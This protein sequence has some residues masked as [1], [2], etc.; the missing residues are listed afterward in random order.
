MVAR[1]VNPDLI[2]PAKLTKKPLYKIPSSTLFLGKNLVSLPECP[3]TNTLALE[4]AQKGKAPDGTV[5]VTR[6]QT[7]G[8]GQRG[9]SWVVGRDLNLTFSVVLSPEFLAVER[10]FDLNKCVSL[11]V[12]DVVSRVAPSTRVKWPNDILIGK[13]KVCGILIENTLSRSRISRS[14]VG[15]GLNVNQTEF[16][17]P[18]ATSLALLTGQSFSLP[19][20]FEQVLQALE[21]RY[22]A[23][24]NGNIDPL[25][26]DYLNALFQMNETHRYSSGD[27]S[28]EGTIRGVTD[29]GKLAMEVAGQLKTFDFKEIKYLL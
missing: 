24:R 8:R 6:H 27:Q 17:V 16:E 5:V 19:E 23:L 4:L 29:V 22:L 7:A 13:Q 3:S 12:H 18:G 1:A 9:N 25:R 21:W 28:F 11:A 2:E 26:S 10:Q 14:V 15:I 20:L